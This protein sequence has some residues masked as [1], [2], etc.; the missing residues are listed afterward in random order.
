MD[1]I[2]GG[3]TM[4]NTNLTDKKSIISLIP[5]QELIEQS[6]VRVDKAISKTIKKRSTKHQI[7]KSNYGNKKPE[8]PER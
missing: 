3:V 6:R 4:V 8:K 1:R 7:D 5:T 2:C